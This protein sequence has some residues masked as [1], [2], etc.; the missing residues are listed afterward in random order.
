MR[1]LHA[2]L[3]LAVLGLYQTVQAAGEPDLTLQFVGTQHPSSFPPLIWLH[4]TNRAYTPLD[5][6]DMMVSSE[7]LIDGK[8]FPRLSTSFG[9][10]PGIPPAGDWEGCLSTEDYAPPITPG[11]HQVSLKMGGTRSNMAE[12][13]WPAP[14]DWRKGDMATRL[15]EVRDLASALKKGLPR[16]CVEQWLTVK[17]GGEQTPHQVRYYLEPQIKVVVPYSQAGDLGNEDEVVSGPVKVY[18]EVRLQD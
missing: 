7:L 11:K 10:R 13:R 8:S 3:F 2:A 4:V 6:M 16:P 12:I 9:G 15:K 5:L 17:D 1:S 14:V 18:Q